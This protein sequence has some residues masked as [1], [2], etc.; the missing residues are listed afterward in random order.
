MLASTHLSLLGDLDDPNDPA[1]PDNLHH[2][3]PLVIHLTAHLTDLRCSVGLSLP[4][5]QLSRP[6]FAELVLASAGR[7]CASVGERAVGFVLAARRADPKGSLRIMGTPDI[8]VGPWRSWE[9][10]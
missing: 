10:V 5:P 2:D 1:D 4:E 9:R 8:G 3:A 7:R 6:G